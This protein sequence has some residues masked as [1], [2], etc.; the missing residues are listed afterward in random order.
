MTPEDGQ[1][2]REIAREEMAAAIE[3]ERERARQI[4]KSLSA[5]PGALHRRIFGD[6]EK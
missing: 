6:Q 2:V 4:L 5:P 1:R 3:A